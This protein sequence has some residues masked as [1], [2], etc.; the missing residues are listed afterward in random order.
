MFDAHKEGGLIGAHAPPHDYIC[1]ICMFYNLYMYN[2]IFCHFSYNYQNLG[3]VKYVC[4]PK[5]IM[6]DTFLGLSFCNVL[7]V[8]L[9]KITLYDF[10][11]FSSLS[12]C[13]LHG[14]V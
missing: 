7:Y 4:A 3:D 1:Y 12:F 13:I 8:V 14:F 6:F 9:R 5:R 2:F 10:D 11:T